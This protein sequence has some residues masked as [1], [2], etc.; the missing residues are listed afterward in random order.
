VVDAGEAF[1]VQL[2]G[3]ENAAGAQEQLTPPDPVSGVEVPVQ[4]EALPEA[5]AIGVVLTTSVADVEVSDW[6]KLSVTTTS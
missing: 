5:D 4:I 3:S 6:V 2:V 1:G